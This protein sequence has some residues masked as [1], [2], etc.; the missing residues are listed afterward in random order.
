M[1]VYTYTHTLL[2]S[3]SNYLGNKIS[4]TLVNLSV[5]RWQEKIRPHSINGLP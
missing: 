4:A 2:H 5:T 1:Y 3:P